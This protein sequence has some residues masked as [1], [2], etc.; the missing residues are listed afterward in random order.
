MCLAGWLE[1]FNVCVFLSIHAKL[2]RLR[3]ALCRVLKMS[4][5]LEGLRSFFDFLLHL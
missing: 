5:P 4:L 2:S 3:C 1:T